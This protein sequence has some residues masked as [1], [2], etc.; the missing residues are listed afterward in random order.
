MKQKTH[1]YKGWAIEK[2]W[3]GY[4]DLKIGFEARP[5]N[6]FREQKRE[7][8]KNYPLRELAWHQPDENE[9]PCRC[10]ECNYTDEEMEVL[11][12]KQEEERK[13]KLTMT[14]ASFCMKTL[15]SCKAEIDTRD[16]SKDY[17]CKN[18]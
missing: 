8:V 6:W 5:I 15:K 2:F 3:D 7:L 12:A 17:P 16:G 9:M 1:L 18:N 4:D 13:I 10:S 14:V 11:K